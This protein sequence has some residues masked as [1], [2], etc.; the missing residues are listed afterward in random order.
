MVSEDSIFVRGSDILFLYVD[1]IFFFSNDTNVVERELME[2]FD[3]KKD[4]F[5]GI[6]TGAYGG[7]HMYEKIEGE[8]KI[9]EFSQKNISVM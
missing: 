5:E 9:F 4:D 2:D 6:N 7:I 8:F 1:D 3:L